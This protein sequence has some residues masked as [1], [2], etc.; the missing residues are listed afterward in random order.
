MALVLTEEQSMLRDSA[1]GLISDKAPVAHLRS[2]RDAK[3]ATGF[4]RDLWKTFAEMGFSGLLVPDQFGGSGLGCVEAGIVMEEIGR[5]LMPSPFLATS[6]LA[7]SALSRGGSEAQKAQH[8]PK[9]ADGSLLAALAIDEGAKHRPLQTK[10]QATRSGNGFK[11]SGDKGFVVDGHTADLLIVAARTAGSAGDKNG[12]TLFLVDPKAKGLAVERTA[13]VD[14]HNAA[15]I[16]FD[17][18]EVDADS[19]LG[20]VDQ[21][22]GL[23]EGVL[24]I[25]RGAVASEMVGLSDEV[26]GRTVAYLKE[27]KQFGKAIGEF[28]ALQHR[29]AQLYI[30]I[31]ITRA[32]VLKALQALDTDI[33]KAA[34]AVAVAKARAGTTA[35]LAVQEGVQ[36][37]GG[38][39]MTDQFDI[40]F[41]MKRA[42]VCQE[43]FGDSNFHTDQL[44]SGKGY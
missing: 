23:L 26:F 30:D 11:L 37:H 28:Q 15:R 12:L 19:V 35:T 21:G 25:G 16:V 22:F 2:L 9:I 1:R 20:E 27:R 38:M 43:L 7:A 33:D 42:R 8:L 40:G 3:D 6:V 36:M 14:S 4:S 10:L 44:A 32:A 34:T 31:E 5:T 29:A 17:N 39:G 24:N 41:F 18:V 13:M